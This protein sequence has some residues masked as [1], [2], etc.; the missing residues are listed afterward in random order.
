MGGYAQLDG[1]KPPTVRDHTALWMRLHPVGSVSGPLL[2]AVVE[3]CDK[4]R[5]SPAALEALDTRVKRDTEMGPCLAYAGWNGNGRVVA[6]KYRPM[7]GTSHDSYAERPSVWLRPIIVG[8]RDSL[9]WL[10]AE[11]ETDAARLWG[12]VGDRCAILVLPA[13]ARAFDKAWAALV[14][15]GAGVGLCHDADEDGDA[16]AAKAAQIIGAGTFRVRPPVEGGDWCDWAGTAHDFAKLARPGARYGFTTYAEFAT[17]DFPEASPLLGEAGKVFL[18]VGS[19]LMVWGAAGSGKSTWTIDGIVH[20][21]AGADWL[22]VPVPRSVRVCIIENE[23]PPSLFQERLAEKLAAWDG[24]RDP[25]SHLHVYTVPWGGFSF[26]DP[27]ARAALRAYCDEHDI[28]LVTA[29]PTLGLGVGASGR[30]D[31][32]QQFVEWLVECGLWGERAFILNHHQ[33]KAGQVSGDWERHPD[34][35]VFLKRDGN[36]QRTKLDWSKT[37][38]ATLDPEEKVVM[39][40][41]TTASWGYTVTKLDAGTPS[42]EEQIDRLNEW[43]T[44]HPERSTTEVLANVEG[45]DARKRRLLKAHFDH[46][47]GKRGAALWLPRSADPESSAPGSDDPGEMSSGR[48]AGVGGKPR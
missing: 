44:A 37:R 20:L 16:G 15:R 21:A 35:N 11:G 1:K 40:E 13:G 19:L 10:I 2:S 48:W 8:N 34:T 29:N 38:W 39:L 24:G 23:G 31:D 26:R 3:F 17:R 28:E 42:D 22:G 33:N 6:I 12:L 5:I 9:N 18:G 32:T 7:N 14:P 47:N 30:P 36:R 27:D 4:K 46:L 43:I 41:W 25:A 45:K